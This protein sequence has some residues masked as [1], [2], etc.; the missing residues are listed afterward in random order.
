M[1]KVFKNSQLYEFGEDQFLK[2]RRI[3]LF[4]D[5]HGDY[6]IFSSLLKILDPSKDGIIFLGD[7]GDRGTKGIKVIDSARARFL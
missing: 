4:G 1:K 3:A 5:I 6:N 2:F 7:Y